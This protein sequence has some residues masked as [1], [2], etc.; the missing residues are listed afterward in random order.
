MKTV[1]SILAAGAVSLFAS[2]NAAI[3]TFDLTSIDDNVAEAT[4]EQDGVELKL[5]NATDLAGNAINFRNILGG[6]A[7]SG[8][9]TPAA[10]DFTVSTN[11]RLVSYT[12][13]N[14]ESSTPSG[15]GGDFIN[16]YFNVFQNALE[17]RANEVD[18]LGTHDFTNLSSLFLAN[19]ATNFMT[20]D[21]INNVL[22]GTESEV[23]VLSRITIEIMDEVV[24]TPI[25][26]ALPLFLFGAGGI[27]LIAR[28]R[29]KKA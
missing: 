12:V 24:E 3:I 19:T 8:N 22:L 1:M 10:F 18:E 23:F 21:L 28:R 5:F 16:Y 26:A 20:G 25:P 27:G 4:V 6:L 2:A 14:T 15:N 17:S 11:F 29:A 9:V 13:V 7:L